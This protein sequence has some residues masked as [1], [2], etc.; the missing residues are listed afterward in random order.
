MISAKELKQAVAQCTG[1]DK[2]YKAAMFPKSRY[3]DGVKLFY[4]KAESYWLVNDILL[5]VNYSKLDK[6]E[7]LCIKMRVNDGKGDLIFD[8]GNGNVLEKQH[9]NF[10]DLPDGE[11]KFYYIDGV[12]LLP[13]E[14]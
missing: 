12:L 5:Y 6:E 10:C 1:T 7:F 9:Y 4:E 2:Y 13:S 3:T 11:W 14:Y 8:D